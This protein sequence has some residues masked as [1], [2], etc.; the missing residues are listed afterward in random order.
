MTGKGQAWSRVTIP[1]SGTPGEAMA[2]DLAARIAE[3][4]G[5]ELNVLFTPPDPAELSP[6]LGEGFMGTVQM[7]T[8]DSLKAASEEAELMARSQF[9][10]LG[11]A[12]K[13][14]AALES[15][16]WQDL[17]CETRLSDLVV[18]GE[19]SAKGQGMLAE[20]FQQVLMEERAGV[21]V[22]RKPF[23]IDGTA[24]VAWDGKEPSS[25]AARR[26]VALL[27]RASKVVIVG[28]P[29]G[30]NPPKLEKLA[31]Y[32]AAHGI[33]AEVNVLPKGEIH[34]QL[35]EA[36]ERHN[37]DYMVAGAYGRSRLR[38]FAFGGTTR[39]LLQNTSLNLYMAH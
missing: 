28:A 20:A 1:V 11:Y 14:F 25:R 29:L 22:A 18:F 3:V 5:A 7:S 6:W 9:G 24:V 13:S 16:V 19:S 27:K 33:V 26:A 36:S 23:S 34:T 8:L 2:L 31:A 38:E 17:A 12:G 30:E 39:Y 15:P 32:Y 35:A 10:A 21:F 4:F 37:A